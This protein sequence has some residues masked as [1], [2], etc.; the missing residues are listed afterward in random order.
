MVL[1]FL[2]IAAETELAEKALGIL[3][4]NCYSCHGSAAMAGLRLDRPEG[5]EDA[6]VVPGKPDQS[7]LWLMMNGKGRAMMPPT[8]KLAPGDLAAVRE[9]IKAGAKWPVASGKAPLAKW[10]TGL[11]R[12]SWRRRA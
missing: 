2:L 7:R 8:G 5:L 10:W 6:I 9:W 12:P 4:R 3:N 11:S 1:L